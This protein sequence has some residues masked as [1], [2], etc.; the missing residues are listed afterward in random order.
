M[1][2]V[3]HAIKLRVGTKAKSLITHCSTS[4]SIFFTSARKDA[5]DAIAV[6]KA[7]FCWVYA[8]A[9]A[10]AGLNTLINFN[11]SDEC[12]CKSPA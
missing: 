3:L 4:S 7:L 2:V 10:L 11:E 6:A 8:F 12:M 5:A 9:V 1:S